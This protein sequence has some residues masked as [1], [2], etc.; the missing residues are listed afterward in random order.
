MAEYKDPELSSSHERNKSTTICKTAVN[1]KG[2]NLSEN[3]F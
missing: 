1:E 2:E 3:I